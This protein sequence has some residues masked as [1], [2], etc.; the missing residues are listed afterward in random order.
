MDR[1]LV[2]DQGKI[3]EDGTHDELLKHGGLYKTL[4]EAQIEGFLPDKREEINE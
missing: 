3:V 4:W 1:I 2:F